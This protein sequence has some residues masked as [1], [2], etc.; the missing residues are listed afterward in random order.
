MD[1]R[2][3][4]KYIENIFN[5]TC[6]SE[7]CALIRSDLNALNKK[8]L[9][10]QSEERQFIKNIEVYDEK[11]KNYEKD[12]TIKIDAIKEKINYL[13]NEIKEIDIK[14]WDTESFY[15]KLDAIELK[16]EKVVSKTKEI[17]TVLIKLNSEN[18]YITNELK[19]Y[20]EI[21]DIIC[22]DCKEKV[23]NKYTFEIEKKFKKNEENIKKLT[24]K[25]QLLKNKND[26]LS[27]SKLKLKRY[28]DGIEKKN[29][30]VKI[31]E[32]NIKHKNEKIEEYSK[33]IQELKNEENPFKD[34]L[35]NTKSDL[36]KTKNILNEHYV[37]KKDL[38]ILEYVVSEDG[39][40]KFVIKD[41]IKV[42][43]SLIM[44]YLK[45]MGAE[46][47]VYFDNAFNCTFLTNT[48]ECDYSSFSNGEV[49]R[50]NLATLLAFRDILSTNGLIS[51][52]FVLDE[53]I[54][55][56]IDEYA[57]SAIL[58]LLKAESIKNNQTIY[59]V[60]HRT[61]TIKNGLFDNIIQIEKENSISKIVN[62]NQ[63]M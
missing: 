51:N 7:M 58:N 39:A 48:G 8:I 18:K 49:Q 5:I 13:K 27:E 54:D 21:N 46:F 23:G 6:F 28:I 31:N 56:G 59:I 3:K 50:I 24:D 1:K 17:N 38:E 43:N 55:T 2:G 33:N 53:I 20:K 41:L 10:E 14:H 16:L 32:L 37:D 57:L 52:I 12:K 34:I 30:Q 62:D 45:E 42:L 63:G 19:K 40:K 61:E 26:D 25:L 60:S 4:V 44:K 15:K 36:K 29:E 47:T 9:V 22:D 11:L 35:K